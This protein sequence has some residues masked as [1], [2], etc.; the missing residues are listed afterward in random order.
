MGSRFC[1]GRIHCEHT[2]FE[3]LFRYPA[4]DVEQVVRYAGMEF[5]REVWAKVSN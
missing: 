2:E 3:M 1:E 5:G 4:G